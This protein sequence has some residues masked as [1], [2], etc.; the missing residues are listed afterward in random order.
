MGPKD[1]LGSPEEGIEGAREGGE[2]GLIMGQGPMDSMGS[3]KRMEGG[4]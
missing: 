2:R 3:P 1:S 4:T